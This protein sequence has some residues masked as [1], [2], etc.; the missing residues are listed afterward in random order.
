MNLKHAA[1]SGAIWRYFEHFST[2]IISV[3]VSIVLARIIS[4]EAYGLI[5]TVNIFIAIA[6]I[7]V[8]GGMG[9]ALVQD[10]DADI[11]DFSTVLW[12]NLGISIGIYLILFVAAPWIGVYFKQPEL[13]PI[14]R[15]LG[16]SIPISAVGS[17]QQ[18]YVSKK[19]IFKKFF[20]A[21]FGGTAASGIIGLWMAYSGFGVWALVGQHLSNLLIDTIILACVLRV[22]Y[23]FAFSKERFR[24]LFG[25]GGKLLFTNVIDVIFAN[26][27]SLLIGRYYSQSDL[28]FFSKAQQF[29]GLIINNI[30]NTITGVMF[31]MMAASQKNLP[32]MK[33]MMR[34]V[35]Q[36]S[37][38]FIFPMLAG[39]LMVA[40]PFIVVLLTEKWV[41]CVPYMQLACLTNILMPLQVANLEI[42]KALGRGDIVV[43]VNLYKKVFFVLTLIAVYFSVFWIA[44]ASF[45]GSILS[46]IVN[47]WPNGALIDYSLR[48][49]IWD[50]RENIGNT[51]IMCMAVYAVGVLP[52]DPY[53]MLLLQ[54]SVGVI[55]YT[56]LALATK[57][58]AVEFIFRTARE[59]KVSRQKHGEEK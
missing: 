50:I 6:N 59:W 41:L 17:I 23:V 24:K 35:I 39:L 4:V 57:P 14:L 9:N 10:P 45:I 46:L 18:A 13:V 37:T 44:V 22:R 40:E 19:M 1:V 7:F 20:W 33:N 54:I 32:Q 3:V 15:V 27:R 26:L 51:L 2:E 42:P 43:K 34:R 28:A 30:N 55:V 12:G 52:V 31:P 48:Q 11:H 36:T 8:T 38:F 5:A 47:A 29:P 21:S 49:Q 58:P 25:F 56:V 16:V 53:L